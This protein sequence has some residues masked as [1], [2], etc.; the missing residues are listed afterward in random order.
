MSK[1]RSLL[2]EGALVTVVSPAYVD[3]PNKKDPV[4][5]CFAAA[6]GSLKENVHVSKGSAYIC[7]Y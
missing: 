3:W 2:S 5:I 6:N 4:S 1:K 7:S